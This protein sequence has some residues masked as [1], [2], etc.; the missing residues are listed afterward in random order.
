MH[1]Q[2]THNYCAMH[3]CPAS[4]LLVVQAEQKAHSLVQDSSSVDHTSDDSRR[5]SILDNYRFSRS[6]E[7]VHP[8]S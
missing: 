7:R 8:P 5:N 3:C 4:S 6:N 2:S 1:E